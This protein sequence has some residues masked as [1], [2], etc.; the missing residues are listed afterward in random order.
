[1]VD[2]RA[3]PGPPAPSV[4]SGGPPPIRRRR[5]RVWPWI[6]VPVV[7][8]LLAGTAVVVAGGVLLFGVWAPVSTVGTLDFANPVRIPPLAEPTVDADGTKVFDL[9]LQAGTTSFLPGAPTATWGL[10]GSYLSPTLRAT[11]G[12]RVRVDLTNGVDEPTTLHWHGMHLPATADGGPHQM[13]A[14]GETW[15]PSWTI[16]Q[17]ASTLWFHPH[18][19]E[20]TGAHVLR[21]AAGMFLLDDPAGA[22]EGLPEEYGVDDIPLIVQDRTFDADNQFGAREPLFGQMG[23]LG[24]Q[25]LVNG[26]A[27]P[28]LEVT[29]ERV[30]LRLLNA[31][32]A[33]IYNFAFDDDRTFDLVGTDGGLLE[34]PA[35]LD[36]LQLSPGERAEVVVAVAPG[37]R[38][39]L[40]SRDVAIRPRASGDERFVG[41]EDEFD[42]VQLRAADALVP[43]PPLPDELAVIQRPDAD[44]AATTRSYRLDNNRINGREMDMA[45]I[46]EVVTVGTTEVW[47][48]TNAHNLPH[49]FHPH[50]VHVVVL[51]VDGAPPPASLSGWKDTIYVPPGSTVRIAM[52]FE[53]H[54][55]PSTPY[56]FH[57]HILRHEDSGMMG[58]FVVVEPGGSPGVPAA[59]H[60]GHGG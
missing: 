57:C 59:T 38:T 3:F 54:A 23:P 9:R 39:V 47:E 44:E 28:H 36:A 21:G 24:D 10:N 37:E 16:D 7:L 34:R 25:L 5:R 42:V 52:R 13:V 14:P 17:P 40:Q 58:Q 51:D 50:L 53:D 8:V 18:L 31:S 27:N 1:M 32:N 60:D 29:T 49:S 35:P 12:D 41:A 11:R 33:R 30:R 46:D 26:T 43:S 48:V 56:M 55:D 6:A 45:R 4:P 2:T 19:H 20:Q 15:S 22:P